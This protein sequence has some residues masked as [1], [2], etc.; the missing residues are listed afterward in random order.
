ME[1]II[2]LIGALMMMGGLA[3]Y[4][5]RFT[6]PENEETGESIH[7][8]KVA[9]NDKL[10]VPISVMLIGNAQDLFKV[11]GYRMPER[12]LKANGLGAVV[13][14]EN[15][16]PNGD[17]P[18]KMCLITQQALIYDLVDLMV[19]S[20]GIVIKDMSQ[21]SGKGT[22]GDPE[23][24]HHLD[25]YQPKDPVSVQIE[26]KDMAGSRTKYVG[27]EVNRLG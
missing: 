16:I 4:Q 13:S 10:V 25:Q 20:K 19:E 14:F 1:I 17:W 3:K 6:R 9:V 26:H 15:E 21:K 11:F 22:K 5:P 2:M 7:W 12:F 24:V 23:V 18:Y 27:T 8:F